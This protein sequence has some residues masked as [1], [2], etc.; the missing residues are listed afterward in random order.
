MSQ[1]FQQ[2]NVSP[3][4]TAVRLVSNVNVSGTYFNGNS[5]NGVGATLTV[6]ASSLTVDS[7][8]ANVGDRILLQNQ[9]SAF[10]NGIFVVNSIG[11]TVILQRSADMQS[12]EQ[13]KTGQYVSVSAGTALAGSAFVLVE[14]LPAVLG[15]N[16]QSWV[17]A[18]AVSNIALPTIA[19]HI[20]TYT[21][22]SGALGE[23]AA[24][25]INGGNIQAG[26]SGTA[27]SLISF[28]ATATTGSLA[29][30]AVAS[31]GNF[32][33]V[34][35]NASLGQASTWSLADPGAA[36]SKIIQAAGSLVSG[37]FLQN[38]GTA[39]LAVDSGL[40]V[41]NVMSLAASN[42]MAAGGA[43][44]FTKVNGTEAGNAVTAS[45][46]AG[47]ITTSSLTTAAG[48]AYSITWTNTKITATSVVLVSVSG[49]TNTRETL[50]LTCAPGSGSATL[51][52]NNIGPTNALN[53]TLLI[54]YL[55]V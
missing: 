42:A 22:T 6:A 45:G 12:I 29:L 3:W 36:T 53:G 20:A 33:G 47:V 18:S 23:D 2:Y 39:G 49:G 41:S 15:V 35:S 28:P 55:V 14:S 8:S 43:I 10:Q 54:S 26:L 16:T 17:D 11:S 7:V 30:T 13:Y 5:N 1:V 52:I 37:N 9:T 46:V 44:V 51:V 24:T 38:S 27:G 25:A 48:S 32:A 34:I 50:F 19:N 21:N 4:L 40:A 31:S